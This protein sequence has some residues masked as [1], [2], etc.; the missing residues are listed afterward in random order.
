MIP[1]SIDSNFQKFTLIS[2]QL[3]LYEGE[4]FITFKNEVSLTNI[5]IYMENSSHWVILKNEIYPNNDVPV[6]LMS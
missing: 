4:N 3:R 1:D 6:L 2:S 5:R